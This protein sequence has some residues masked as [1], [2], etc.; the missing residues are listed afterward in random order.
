M[1]RTRLLIIQPTAFCNIDCSY[2]Y[3]PDRSSKA[4]VEYPTLW[5]LFSQLFASGWVRDRLD[6]VWH[7]GEPMVL[8]ID[9][10]REALRM[11]DRLRP[12]TLRGGANLPLH[13]PTALEISGCLVDMDQIL[14]ERYCR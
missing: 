14:M 2:C 9:F 7:A 4:V 8:P 11:I 6:V 12:R 3:L 5:N 10:Y 13:G 1:P